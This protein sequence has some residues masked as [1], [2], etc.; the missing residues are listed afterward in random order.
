LLEQAR[1]DEGLAFVKKGRDLLPARDPLREQTRPLLQ[2]CQRYL[3]L[4]TRLPRI[5]KGAEKPANAAE[6]IE[7]A[8]L[9]VLKKL[10]AAAARFYDDAFT[11]E[12]KLAEAVPTGTRYYA[13]CAAAQ[14]GCARGRDA[15]TL[16]DKERARWRRQA[17]EWLRQNLTWWGKALD[18]GNAQT[19]ADVRWRMQ[20]WQTDGDFAGL[21]EPGA[22][23]AL[24]P[25]E[26]EE[27]RALWQEVAALLRR[28]QTTK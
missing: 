20:F 11:A 17:R 10:Y 24:S 3:A 1:F 9:C 21:R 12:P 22:L 6:Q 2:R 19:K 13:A 14:A 23:E 7:V 25:D 15:D 8:Q 27:C 28:V 26:R 5:L 16:D 18:N 4:D